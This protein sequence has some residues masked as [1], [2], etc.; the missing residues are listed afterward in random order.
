MMSG[1][2]DNL[3]GTSMEFVAMMDCARAVPI[4]FGLKAPG[5]IAA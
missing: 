1:R 5:A 3:V 4:A 2:F